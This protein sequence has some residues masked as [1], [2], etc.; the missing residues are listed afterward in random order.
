MGSDAIAVL[1]LNLFCVPLCTQ[2]VFAFA[3]LKPTVQLWRCNLTHVFLWLP[4]HIGCDLVAL[5]PQKNTFVDS[6]ASYFIGVNSEPLWE[7]SQKGCE[8]LFPQAHQKYD[9]PAS[10]STA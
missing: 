1:C 9:L 7:P 10:T 4:S 2:K 8:L 5:Q 3:R 6:V